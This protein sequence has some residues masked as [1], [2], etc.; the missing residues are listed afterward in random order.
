VKLHDVTIPKIAFFK[1]LLAGFE[2]HTTLV[3]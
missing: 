2:V 3:M 1:N